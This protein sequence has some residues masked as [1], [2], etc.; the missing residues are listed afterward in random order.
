[1]GWWMVGKVIVRRAL[2]LPGLLDFNHMKSYRCQEE[3]EILL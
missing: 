3:K 1:M 2:T